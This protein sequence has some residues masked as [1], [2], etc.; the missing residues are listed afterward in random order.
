METRTRFGP[1]PSAVGTPTLADALLAALFAHGAREIFGI[2]GDFALPLFDAIERND[3]LP[4]YTLSHEPSLAF[5]ADAAARMRGAPSVVAVTYGAGALNL[6]NPIAAAYAEKSPVVVLSAAPGAGERESGLL[7]H[8]QAKTLDSQFQIFRE[9]TCDQVRLDDPR[10][11]PAAIARVLASARR[12]SRPVYLEIP[13]DAV[14]MPCE[15]MQALADALP[16]ADA[17]RSCAEEIL[18]RLAAAKRPVLMVGVEVRRFGLD[19]RVARLAR[20]LRIPVVT[21]LLGR[22]LLA[23][24]DAPLCGTYL[25]LAGDPAVSVLV[26]D[27]DGLFLLGEIIADTTFGVSRRRI[28]LRHAIQAL[29]GRVTISHHT[30][31]NIPLGML[32]D[33]LERHARPLA[34]ARRAAPRAPPAKLQA[35]G[36]PVTPLDIAR[37]VNDLMALHGRFPI[38]TDVG[39][40]LFTAMDLLQTDHVAPGYYATM[41]FGTPAALGIQA[42]TGR[43]PIALVG[44]GAFQMTGWELGHCRRHGWDPIVIVMNNA[45]WGMLSAFRP[46]ARYTELGTWD[47]AGCAAPLGGIGHR[48]ETREQ[49]QSA[50][51]TA[52]G[53]R[54]R[55]HLLDV[56]IGPGTLSPTLRGFVQALS[57]STR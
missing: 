32:I 5:A 48:V 19:E 8:H 49:L 13:R 18:L 6:V 31:P 52:A 37:G 12:F 39:D 26:E 27:S 47:F 23:N 11:A 16:D 33:A 57:R 28:D 51:A 56:R 41:G 36:A 10:Q 44:D 2:P 50:L 14:D 43:R 21:S 42:A 35:D 9:I 3:Q 20:A 7:V 4:L 55:F 46:E 25:G 29:D 40:C 38:A 17:L 53:E 45:Q 54:G 30:Y 1:P 22:G 24:A 34:Q 15:P